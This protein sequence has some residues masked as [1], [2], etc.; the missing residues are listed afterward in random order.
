MGHMPSLISLDLTG[1]CLTDQVHDLLYQYTIIYQDFIQGVTAL[2]HN[3]Q[4]RNLVLAECPEITDLGMEVRITKC[5][6]VCN[7]LLS[8]YCQK[9]LV[10]LPHLE[11]LDLS[12]CEQITDATIKAIVFHCRLLRSLN[13]SGCSRVSCCTAG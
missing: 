2:G 3:P 11:L 1:C 8:I 12:D 7:V 10:N 9:M 13:V 4:F 6:V 5:N